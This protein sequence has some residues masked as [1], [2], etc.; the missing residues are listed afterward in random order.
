MH[1]K[2]GDKEIPL[3]RP[4]IMAI[5]NTTPDSFYD[6]GSLPNIKSALRRAI[7][8]VDEG[9]DM[10]DIGGESTRPG[11]ARVDPHEQIS[12]VVPVIAAIRAE[13]PTIPISVDTTLSAV[14]EAALDA[15]ADAINDV[16]GATEDPAMLDLVASR[17]CGLV[18]MHRLTTPDQDSYSDEYEQPPTYDDVVD[19]VR[20]F[21]SDRVARA[22]LAGISPEYLL[23][24]PGLGFGKSV[25]QNLELIR[26]TGEL[27]GIGAGVLSGISR[28]SFTGAGG[29]KPDDRLGSTLDLGV[30]HMKAGARVFRVHDVAEHAAVLRSAWAAG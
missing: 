18:L 6:G 10:L 24:D 13:L 26:R 1:W 22:Q 12:R 17:G 29:S 5:L 19:E 2:L 28:K 15:G 11:S 8:C 27:S 25:E 3:D 16:S 30:V 9:A 14:G 21:L 7:E 20:R 4:R 23:V